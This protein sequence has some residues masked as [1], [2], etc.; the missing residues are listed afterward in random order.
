MGGALSR[1]SAGSQPPKERS[2]E[3]VKDHRVQ[4]E[5]ASLA[6]MDRPP[7]SVKISHLAPPQMRY[8]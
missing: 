4:D 6:T 2:E 5:F 3:A 8:T 7:P 1:F